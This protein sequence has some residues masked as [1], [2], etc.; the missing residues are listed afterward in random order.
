MGWPLSQDYNEAV[1]APRASFADPELKGCEVVTGPLGL[2]LPRSGNFADVYQVRG[3]DGRTWAVKCFTRPVAG[4][5]E[6]YAKI[7]LHLQEARLPF[8]VGFRFLTEG[9]KVRGQWYP[10]VK[11]EWVEGFTLN[12]FV[13]NQLGRADML[14]AL[15]GM[16]VRLC[17]RLRDAEIAHADLQHGNVLLVPGETANKLKLRLIDYDGMWVPDLAKKP[18]G[19]SGHPAYQHPARLRDKVYSADVDRFPHLVIG[20]ALRA[21][22]VAGKPLFDQFD[23]GDNLLFR[24][25]DFARPGESKVF[26]TLWDLDDPTVT[27]LVALLVTSAG[28]P[29][30]DT[31]WLDE[32]LEGDQAQPVSDAVLSKA[33]TVLG[34]PRR[35]S[36]R[37]APA[38]QIY[39]VPEE[40]NAFANLLDDVETRPK[41]PRRKRKVPVIPLIAGGAV[42]VA[43]GVMLAIL[44]TRGKKDDPGPGPDGTTLVA[45]VTTT[46][47]P[48]K[49]GPVVK[50]GV[51]ETQWSAVEPGKPVIRVPALA[52]GIDPPMAEHFLRPYAV[53]GAGALGVWLLPDGARAIIAGRAAVNVL[54]LKTGKMEPVADELDLVRAAVSPDG[55]YVVTA[56]RERIVRGFDVESGD[57]LF[58]RGF[59][60]TETVLAV[61]PDGKRVALTAPGVGY[62]EWT[63][64]EGNEVRRH[65]SMQATALAFSP[66]G[67]S[68]VAT[69]KDGGVEL[70]SLDDG[71]VK[72]LAADVRTAAVGFS[73]DGNRAVAATTAPGREIRSWTVPDG[74]PLPARPLPVKSG[75]TSLVVAADGTAFVGT[76]SGEV[77]FIPEGAP[78]GV[79]HTA[80]PASPISRLDLTADSKHVLAGTQRGSVYL[81]RTTPAPE[82]IEKKELPPSPAPSWLA[83]VRTGPVSPELRQFAADARGDR[84]LVYG[85]DRVAI[86]ETETLRQKDSLRIAEGQI[87]A[88]GFG[89][90]GL[91]VL[92]E[93]DA[94]GKYRTRAWNPTTTEAGPVFV[95]PAPKETPFAGLATRITPVPERPWVLAT[96]PTSGDVLFDPKTGKRVEGWPAGQPSSQLVAAPSPDG[97]VIAFGSADQT[98]Q[99]WDSDKATPGLKFEASTGFAGLA[100]S[101][102]GRQLVGFGRWGRIRVWDATTGKIVREVDHDHPGPISN[103]VPLGGDLAAVQMNTG[104]QVMDLVSGRVAG[105]GSD[106]PVPLGTAV[107]LARRGQFVARAAD[108]L[109]ATWTVRPERVATAPA[110]RPAPPSMFPD[111]KVIRDAPRGMPIG[112]AVTADAQYVISADASRLT[113]YTADR[114][115]FDTEVES[116]EGPLRGL[117]LTKDKLFTLGRKSVG[118]RDPETLEKTAEFPVTIGTGANPVLFAVHPD[119]ETAIIFSDRVRE[120]D[121]KTKRERVVPTPR[122]ASGKPLTQFAWSKDGRTGVAR[123][124]NE[125]TI[126][127]NPKTGEAKSLEDLK[128]PAPAAPQALAV[129]D[130]GV[131]AALGTRAGE[132][133]V[134]NTRTNKVLLSETGVYPSGA[135]G[136]GVEAVWFLQGGDHVVTVGTNGQVVVWKID[137]AR[138]IEEFKEPPGTIRGAL[139]PNGRVLFTQLPSTMHRIELPNVR[140]KK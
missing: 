39:S 29:M 60:A 26:R 36:R 84:F 53:R 48:D 51:L 121:L 79:V 127:W 132:L 112:L 73:A 120:L 4:L 118:V 25:G 134:W 103:V 7:D 10:V 5:K 116:D 47:E 57:E 40:A 71:S 88:A 78:S 100:F 96:T 123:W 130:D 110:L 3:P 81:S 80:N 16:W 54:D 12:E 98:V 129:S 27:N 18:S 28:R 1:Q 63:L 67:K 93:K 14:K 13:R 113:R 9:I 109:L 61:T 82:E 58:A 33:A 37:A 74:R 43:A 86:Y 119:G 83:F 77:A 2:P 34:V 11:M 76:Q 30:R 24:E 6:R 59:P 52:A 106:I 66:D 31:P 92:C 46:T 117:A 107:V 23:N 85:R 89:P 95:L 69:D 68:A 50:K 64:P 15:L 49:S 19:E 137:G 8:T 62:A 70:W 17:K 108:D 21:I 122:A 91:V 22:A 131:L 38:A 124:A 104:W 90:G 111:V 72:L 133:K 139:G 87:T 55:K 135:G 32:V 114:L 44:L 138:R 75:V 115:R 101:P 102:D 126:V 140:R 125:I 20:C 45:G 136:T 35:A 97:K 56:D 65:S 94:A 105:S 42:V 41:R 99:L 128:A